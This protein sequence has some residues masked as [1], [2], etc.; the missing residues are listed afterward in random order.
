MRTIVFF[1]CFLLLILTS[2]KPEVERVEVIYPNHSF[3]IGQSL[4]DFKKEC[5]CHLEEPDN[6]GGR[7]GE[8][9]FTFKD[10]LDGTVTSNA[11]MVFYKDVLV[12]FQS[13]FSAIDS[14]YNMH[15]WMRK[16]Y[17]EIANRSQSNKS[18]S[19]KD[20]VQTVKIGN[21]YTSLQLS[22]SYLNIP[23][24]H[25]LVGDYRFKQVDWD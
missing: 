22:K 25:Y 20:F 4:T 12:S 8:R 23:F 1:I 7:K 17:S 16:H 2:C 15:S 11:F 19:E 9:Y 3:F 24:L 6:D 18:V 14:R 21:S 10:S 5:N 13:T